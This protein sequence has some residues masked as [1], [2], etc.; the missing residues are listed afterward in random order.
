[1]ATNPTIDDTSDADVFYCARHPQVET[2][3]RC[4]RCD[5]PIC[6]RCLVQTPVG[7]KCPTC[8]K[9][10]RLPTV[11]ISLMNLSWAF[12]AATVSGTVVG[13]AWGYLMASAGILGFFLIFI[14]VGMGWAVG[15]SIAIA[16]N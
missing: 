14:A 12:G 10:S 6:P 13:A 9:V 11:D 15:E 7:A 5:T 1:M 16:A 2:V 4:N 8:A 3:L